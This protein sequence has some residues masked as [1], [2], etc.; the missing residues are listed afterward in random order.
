MRE[1]GG[2][3]G[4]EPRQGSGPADG[5]GERPTGAGI[6]TGIRTG[7]GAGIGAVA[8]IG[9]LG[10]RPH[11]EGGWYRELHRSTVMVQRERDGALRSAQTLI[12]YLLQ[13]G[14]CSRWHRVGGSDEIWFHAAGAPLDLW[15]LPPQG[16][17]A[18]LLG[19]GSL[20]LDPSPSGDR[21]VQVIAADGWQAAR[22]RG[23]WSLVHCA[24]G[25]GF[26]FDD[27]QLLAALPA[28]LRPA[29]ARE[30]LL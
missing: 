21:P 12:A 20:T 2:H 25:P 3:G 10:L 19:L 8:L 15:S 14:E 9:E 29:G 17:T 23:D 13:R 26:A 16:G 7:I 1:T 6:G 30:D 27:F 22:S 28:E 5:M 11:P 18:T 24:V 4:G